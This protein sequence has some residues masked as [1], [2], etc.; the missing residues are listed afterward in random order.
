MHIFLSIPQCLR[1][2]RQAM[3]A[4][5]AL[6]SLSAFA[7]AAEPMRV[8]DFALLDQTGKFHQLSYYG[9]KKA[10]VL[11]VQ[12]NNHSTVERSLPAFKAL[13]DQ[14]AGAE[15]EFL[16]LNPQPGDTRD[17]VASQADAAGYGVPVLLDEAQLVAEALKLTRIGEL[18]I[19]NPKTM[20]VAYRGVLPAASEPQDILSALVDGEAP[21]PVSTE[22][23][24][25]SAKDAIAFPSRAQ[26][27]SQPVSYSRDIVPMLKDNCVSCHQPGGIAP[28]SMN[29]H[30]MVRGFAPM[31][32]E[33]VTTRRMPPGQ[34]DQ[35]LSKPIEHVA[36]L[37]AAEQ[38]ALVHW[39]DAGAPIDGDSDPLT[40]LTFD[41]PRYSMGEPDL[42]YTIPAQSIPAS[43]L[44]DYRYIPLKLN[45]DKDVWI[46]GMEFVPGDRQVLHHV[47]AYVQAPADRSLNGRRDTVARGES[48]GGFAPGRAGEDFGPEGGRLL[49]KGANLLLQMH[50]TTK[51]KAAIDETEIGIYLHDKPP[52]YVMSEVVAAQRRFLV[53]P[54]AKEHQLVGEQV[55]ERDAYL[56]AMMP[57]MHYRGKYMSYTAE[58]P[59]G[60]E[61]L[62]LSVPKYDFNWQFNYK[63][64]EP[65]FLPAGTRLV[66]KGAMDNSDRNP[67]NPD[68]SQPVHFGLQTQHEMFFGFTTLRYTDVQPQSATVADTEQSE[69]PAGTSGA[70]G[71]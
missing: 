58:Y 39:I 1:T 31:I 14:F 5:L 13:R 71:S 17:A 29:S 45:L 11:L 7:A 63:L 36:G 60:T 3:L 8:G 50:Y 27:A 35:H 40:A 12:A 30:T 51:G 61:E 32:K 56:Y 69:Q 25:P 67:G 59:D 16:M 15:V 21:T 47:I 22:L 62:L 54:H 44:V 41:V 57:H 20:S 9:D 53:P 55:I 46:R 2:A 49:Q 68:P 34:I 48:V 24:I 66:A 38:Q 19:V 33:V 65:V 18:L 28:W 23:A 42:I 37:S 26:F 4:G 10:V 70:G 43:G 6:L 64:K 52:K